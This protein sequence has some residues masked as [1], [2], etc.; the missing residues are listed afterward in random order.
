MRNQS[1]L[2]TVIATLMSVVVLGVAVPALASPQLQREQACG[3]GRT[4]TYAGGVN[5]DGGSYEVPLTVR[6]PGAPLANMDPGLRNRL[7]SWKNTSATGAR[8]FYGLNGTGRCVSMFA[9]SQASAAVG[10]PDDNQAES[11]GYDRRCL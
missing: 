6:L 5:H 3:P 9:N 2:S 4:C 10:N 8:F 7:S 1:L 11:H